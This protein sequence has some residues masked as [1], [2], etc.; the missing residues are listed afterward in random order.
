MK[1]NEKILSQVKQQLMESLSKIPD[2]FALEKTKNLLKQTI[3]SI[4]EV[5]NKRKKRAITEAI[6]N[7]PKNPMFFGNIEDAQN[8]I[9]ILDDMINKEQNK[10]DGLQN[11]Q[12]DLLLE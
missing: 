10:I 11:N 4:N 6:N 7:Q 1:R 8:A 12:T 9:K 2:E 5:E 3:T